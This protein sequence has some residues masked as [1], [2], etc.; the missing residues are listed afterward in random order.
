MNAGQMPTLTSEKFQD[1]TPEF[2]DALKQLDKYAVKEVIPFFLHEPKAQDSI[3]TL[4]PEI[5]NYYKEM[6]AKFVTGKEPLTKWDEYVST[7]KKMGSDELVKYYS[8]AY[9]K[10]KNS[11]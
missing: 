8:D 10:W 6:R 4:E 3:N 11:K 5:I 9:E 7:I 2:Q 1:L